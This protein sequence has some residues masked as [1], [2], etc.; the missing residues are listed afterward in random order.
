M[1]DLGIFPFMF[2]GI[3]I[4]QSYNDLTI[5]GFYKI[6]ERMIDGPNDY[7]GTLVVFND[8]GQITQ[9]FYPN[10]DSEKIATRKGSIK[11]FVNSAW[12]SISLT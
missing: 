8:G 10:T 9:V 12:R 4:D 5:T 6:Q 2:R 1:S 3:K 11:D 7:W